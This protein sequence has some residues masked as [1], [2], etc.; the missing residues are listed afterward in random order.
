MSYRSTTTRFSLDR[1]FRFYRL[2]GL[3]GFSFGQNRAWGNY[4]NRHLS[5]TYYTGFG[6]MNLS[7]RKQLLLQ[8]AWQLGFRA[9][10]QPLGSGMAGVEYHPNSRLRLQAQARLDQRRPNFSE[11]Y[12]AYAPYQGN[13]GLQNERMTSYLARLTSRPFESLRIQA[14]AGYR[15]LHNEIRFRQFSFENDPER[16]FF[17]LSA[18]GS[19]DFSVFRISGGGQ[20]SDAETYLSPRR[21]A[22]VQARY[23]DIWLNGAL[24][25][26]AVSTVQAS[27]QHNRILYNPVLERFYLTNET[28][29]SYLFFSY[30]LTATVKDAQLYMAMDNPMGDSFEIIH[31]YPEQFR[32]VRFGVNWVLWN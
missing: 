26:D 8:S 25:L 19:F 15:S 13:P 14:E 31:G 23:H 32:R 20:F 17:Y 4:V 10:A 22:F 27:D 16:S 21:S 2:S 28:A 7:L 12:V 29:A 18:H 9:G 5:D 24:I 11:R 6:T 1:T 3:N 30:K